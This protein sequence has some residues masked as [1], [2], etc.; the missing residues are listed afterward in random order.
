ME[1]QQA[2]ARS[3][4]RVVAKAPE[5]PGKIKT[6]VHLSPEAFRRLGLISFSAG[7]APKTLTVRE[8]RKPSP[9][10]RE[11]A[12]VVSGGVRAGQGRGPV[13]IPPG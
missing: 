7:P 1:T 2:G 5:A 11:R 10:D 12:S 13:S 3:R 8:A 9:G 4:R 6:A